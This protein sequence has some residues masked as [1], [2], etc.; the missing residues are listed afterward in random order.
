[1]RILKD[2]L[3]VGPYLLLI[4]FIVEGMAIISRQW[5]SFPISL[6][7]V[8]QVLLTILCVITCFVCIFWINRPINSIKINLLNRQ[9]ELITFGPF[10]YVRHPLYSS[11]MITIP[12]LLVIWSANLLFFIPWIIII[13]VS[14]FIVAIEERR[15]IIVFGEAYKS[16]RKHVPALIPYKGAIG[17]HFI[18]NK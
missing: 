8:I 3:G 14:H 9:N 18:E 15:L 13:L 6:N 16:Y 2:M 1:M 5:I 12:P 17:K 4:G 10:A 7:P 11:L